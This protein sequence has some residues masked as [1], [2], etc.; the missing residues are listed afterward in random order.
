ML[1]PEQKELADRA[2]Q[3]MED[4]FKLPHEEKVARLLAS[5]LV[6]ENGQLIDR[7][8]GDLRSASN[9]NDSNGG[10]NGN[11]KSHS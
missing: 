11:G 2:H 10:K 4:Y 6:D 7:G 1:S 5:G 8:P 9:G 3:A